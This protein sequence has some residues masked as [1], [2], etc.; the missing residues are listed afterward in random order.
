MSSIISKSLGEP[1]YYASGSAN[2]LP[3][4]YLLP[5]DPKFDF[6]VVPD[7]DNQSVSLRFF[8]PVHYEHDLFVEGKRGM[9]IPKEDRKEVHAKYIELCIKAYEFACF[10]ISIYDKTE[11]KGIFTVSS[12][13]NDN[14]DVDDK[15]E[16]SDDKS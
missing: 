1:V 16:Q 15:K 13:D 11:K 9:E 5:E 3:F 12:P 7:P 14:I 10:I 8:T 6:K 2:K 4:L